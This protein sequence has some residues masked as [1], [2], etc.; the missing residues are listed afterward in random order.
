MQEA[1]VFRVRVEDW[2]NLAYSIFLTLIF[3]FLLSRLV[4]YGLTKIAA[5]T[6][7]EYDDL[8]I[9][10]IRSLVYVIIITFGFQVGTVRLDLIEALVK[11]RI[12]RVYS[13]IYVVAAT[14]ILWRLLDVL[15][16]WYQNDVE[17][18]RNKQQVVPSYYCCIEALKCCWSQSA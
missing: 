8:F 5:R 9:E 2:L 16:K 13:L 6:E 11:I 17:P 7:T 3:G 12:T 10:Q 18:T 1:T 15:V 4:Y 14:V